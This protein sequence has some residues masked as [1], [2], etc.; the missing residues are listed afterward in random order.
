MHVTIEDSHAA[1]PR[2]DWPRLVHLCLGIASPPKKAQYGKAHLSLYGGDWRVCC[3]FVAS[4]VSL[5]QGSTAVVIR[6]P[7]PNPAFSRFRTMAMQLD[8]NK[9]F[10]DLVRDANIPIKPKCELFASKLPN[11]PNGRPT[12]VSCP[13]EHTM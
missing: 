3:G 7:H 8:A 5:E 4:F 13:G 12:L 10:K 9:L 11:A 1:L 2:R 6:L